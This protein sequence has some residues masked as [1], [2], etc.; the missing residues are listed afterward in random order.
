METKPRRGADG[1]CR[2][3]DGRLRRLSVGRRDA[4]FRAG[5][6]KAQLAAPDYQIERVGG[7]VFRPKRSDGSELS[8]HAYGAALDID[9]E[10]NRA[11]RFD[12]GAVPVPWSAK[13]MELWPEGLPRAFVEAME[14]TGL[15]W[16]GRFR[17]FCEPS[18]LPGSGAGRM[19]QEGTMRHVL[20]LVVMVGCVATPQGGREEDPGGPVS[21]VDEG[22]QECRCN[23][24]PPPCCCGTPIVIDT[25]GDGIELTSSKQ[26]VVF[27][28]QQDRFGPWAWT[29]AGSDDAWLVLDNSG[30]GLIEHGSELFGGTM[31]QPKPLVGG[32]LHGF[33]ALGQ[34][35]QNQDGLVDASDEIW[36]ELRLWQDL[37]HDGKS[38][39]EELLA[40]DKIGIAGLSVKYTEHRR[41]DEHGNA[42]RYSADVIPAPGASVGMT[43]WDVVLA[44]ATGKDRVKNVERPAPLPG[45]WTELRR[46]N[47]AFSAPRPSGSI[48]VV[49]DAA[50]A[51]EDDGG[52]LLARLACAWGVHLHNP[53]MH[54]GR[55]S[56]YAYW[57]PGTCSATLAE[58]DVRL[59]LDIAGTDRQ[60]AQ[61][62]LI[63]GPHDW[64]RA[65]VPDCYRTVKHDFYAWVD[66]DV[67]GI[68][69]LP[70]TP[71][72]DTV[73]L[74]CDPIP[75]APGCPN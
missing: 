40:L 6:A 32:E 10:K 47:Q 11:I 67:F 49:T 68:V 9:A 39:A 20:A 3:L 23:A 8:L 61:K 42:F 21:G 17:S 27:E 38:T 26:G 25:A 34:Y 28:L 52:G 4:I 45:S 35:D 5:L 65:T 59:F 44:S 53:H 56:T 1:R 72:T 74:S 18:T 24:E 66:V 46:S 73:E 64:V 7:F 69:D 60:V 70:D 15:V 55:A 37:D 14:S 57:Y 71:L 29:Q 12:R 16:G 2:R 62:E 63:V 54:V 30:E 19:K 41:G 58:V 22:T 50:E 31:P 75:P 43:A 48:D 36:D 13:W 33:N 51:T